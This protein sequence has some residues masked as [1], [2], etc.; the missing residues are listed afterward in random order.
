MRRAL[1][2]FLRYCRNHQA[3]PSFPLLVNVAISAACDLRIKSGLCRGQVVGIVDGYH[4]RDTI[5]TYLLKVRVPFATS[6]NAEGLDEVEILSAR[7]NHREQRVVHKCLEMLFRLEL[8]A[9]VEQLCAQPSLQGQT[10][11]YERPIFQAS[12]QHVPNST[13]TQTE[14]ATALSS[15]HALSLNR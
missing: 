3:Y 13:E 1:G 8:C 14:F 11:E 7:G 15:L 2:A 6:A 4:T 12:E 5:V 10:L 9:A